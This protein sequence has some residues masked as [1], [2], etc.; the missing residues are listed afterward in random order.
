MQ[1]GLIVLAKMTFF[2]KKV[3]RSMIWCGCLEKGGAKVGPDKLGSLFEI[4]IALLHL[5]KKRD[6]TIVLFFFQISNPS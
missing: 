6:K 4:R 5:F 2:L 3:S 1:G